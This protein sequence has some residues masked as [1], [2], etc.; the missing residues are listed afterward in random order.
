MVLS[1]RVLVLAGLVTLAGSA[2]AYD[3][4]FHSTT[5]P[6]DPFVSSVDPAAGRVFLGEL[7]GFPD[8]YEIKR[9]EPFTLRLQLAQPA[10]AGASVE[11]FSLLVVAV[12]PRGSVREVS[13]MPA[14]AMSW[15]R[16]FDHRLGFSLLESQPLTLDVGAGTYRIEVSAAENDGAYLLTL[17]D[18]PVSDH[19]FATLAHIRATQAFL[20]YSPLAL[21]RSAYVLFPLGLLFLIGTGWWVWRIR[22]RERM[23]VRAG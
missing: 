18:D 9:A 21:L 16:S 15:E 13:R 23:Q 5:E 2:L 20:G 10:R 3:P 7:T 8:L 14:D 11:P 1:F 12:D 4:S 17:G 19:Y 6:Y 22:R